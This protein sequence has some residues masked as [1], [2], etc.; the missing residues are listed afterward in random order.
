MD[1]FDDNGF[2]NKYKKILKI[3]NIYKYV[4][5]DGTNKSE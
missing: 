1:Y 2:F 3:K 5:S 4:F